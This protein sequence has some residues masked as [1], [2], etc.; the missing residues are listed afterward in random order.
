[1]MMRLIL[2]SV[3]A[4]AMAQPDAPESEPVEETKE[5]G[6]V[7][8]KFLG[9]SGGFKLF[10]KD[11][12]KSFLMVKQNKLESSKNALN[13]AG[14]K[15]PDEKA[16]S[17]VV[18]EEKDGKTVY[19]LKFDREEQ[20]VK[21][22]LTAHLARDTTTV[23][24]TVDCSGCANNSTGTC[25]NDAKECSDDTDGNCAEGSSPCQ[26]EVEVTKDTL[27]FSIMV[28]GWTF[29]DEN[30]KLTY[31]L[32]LS[33]KGGDKAEK[34]EDKGDKEKRIDLTDGYVEMPTKGKIVGGD[35]E[36]EID[37]KSE[38]SM[39]GQ[40][41]IIN[42]EFPAF[43]AGETLY[44]DPTMAIT[45]SAANMAPSACLFALLVFMAVL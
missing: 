8:V 18:E 24:E 28:S 9:D 34:L 17:D 16:W 40:K 42:F 13:L 1:M 32:E 19:T 31:S 45:N 7:A 14:G 36:R 12:E 6:N 20:D 29:A 44:Y 5:T 27:K 2:L 43:G 4:V 39:Q 25:Q 3:L 35:A 33:S 11:N 26:E 21:F 15:K 41:T 22:S 10:P 38:T 37:V 23:M 30:D